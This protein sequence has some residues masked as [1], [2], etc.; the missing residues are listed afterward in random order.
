MSKKSRDVLLIEI[1]MDFFKATSWT[2]QTWEAFQKFVVDHPKTP[3]QRGLA[4][5]SDG[6][7][8]RDVDGKTIEIVTPVWID[9]K[10]LR[11]N[12]S[13]LF[14]ESGLVRTKEDG[15]VTI[16][17][18]GIVAREGGNQAKFAGKYR[19]LIG[20]P[21]GVSRGKDPSPPAEVDWSVVPD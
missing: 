3:K 9:T 7:I 19:T 12:C 18:G 20:S 8:R 5:T 4:K 14:A 21:E 17:K 2:P 10:A 6:K 11:S 16:T 1:T 13:R 15:T